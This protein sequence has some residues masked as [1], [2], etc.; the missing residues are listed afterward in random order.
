VLLRFDIQVM[1]V[2]L[3]VEDINLGLETLNLNR[4]QHVTD[5]CRVKKKVQLYP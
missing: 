2:G 1:T 5:A 3:P 4:A